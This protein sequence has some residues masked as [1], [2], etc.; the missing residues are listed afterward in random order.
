M[1]GHR[2]ES[3]RL[4]RARRIAASLALIVGVG[5]SFVAEAQSANSGDSPAP[6]PS[7][8]PVAPKPAAPAPAHADQLAPVQITGSRADD[9]QARRNSTAAKIIIGRDEIE[10]FGDSTLGDVLKRLPGVTI[11]GRPGRGGAIRL[12]GLGNGYTQILLDGERVPPGFSLDSLAPDQIERIEILRAPTAETGARAI[13]GTINIITREGYNKRVNDLRLI[14]AWEN[15]ALQPSLAWTRNIVA[16]DWI[17]NYS[18]TA[19][20]QNRDSSSTT[21]TLDNRLDDGSERL[22]QVDVGAVREHRHG[23]HATGRLQ[24]RGE[25]GID[26]LNLTP[27]LIYGRGTTHRQGHLAQTCPDVT[28]PCDPVPYDTATT[29]G[30]G[31]YSLARLNAQ[32]NRRIASGGR[33]ETRAGFGQAYQPSHSFRTE[34]TN[35]AVSRTFEDTGASRDTSYSTGIK[36]TTP[37]FDEHSFVSGAEFELNRRKD[38]RHP[39]ENGVPVASDFGDQLFARALRYA[40]YAQ[41]E[42]SLTPNWA[43]HAGL[44]WEAIA[45]RG[46]A[47][48]GEPDATNRSSVWT[49]LLHAVWKPDPKGRDQ[50]RFSLTRSYRSPTLS[51]LIARTSYNTRYPI[52]GPN[53]PTQ[54]DRAGNPELRPELANGVD[55]AIERYLAGS[56]LLSANVFRRNITNYMRSVTTLQTVSYSSSQRYVLRPENVGDAMTEGVELEAKFR[57]S[58][59]WPETPRVDVRTNASFFRSRVRGVPRPDNRLDQ[60]P[61]YT[62]N[63]GLDY[64]FPGLPFTLGGNL[65]WTPGYLTRISDVQ[66]ATIGRKL[67]AD[68]Y[69]L[70]TFSP[71]LA[72]RVT[73]SNLAAADYVFGS[74]VDGP[75]LQGVPVRESS[76]TTAPTFVNVQLRLEMKL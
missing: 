18:L 27:I 35:G 56:G 60:Q 72:L 13:A 36:L 68:L 9:I 3:R 25:G 43:A 33:V 54:P 19:F 74:S 24:W 8:A 46:T 23:L 40:A 34:L 6:A 10:R 49:P 5:A 73:A 45:T 59:L 42:W 55:I 76:R 30:S 48:Q 14:A 20:A 2:R 65:N 63:L 39:L 4:V 37:L 17:I 47:A 26:Q 12:R 41:D 7:P 53:L 21:T 66:T 44:R 61:D 38:T 31:S 64:R 58:D 15:Q 11:Q 1:G 52:S 50:V 75:D 28:P 67:V 16:G 29:E 32:W 22:G 69:G 57:M 71:T 51:N 70:W 62:A